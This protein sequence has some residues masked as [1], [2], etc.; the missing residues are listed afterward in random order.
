M[1]LTPAE[2]QAAGLKTGRVQD[3]PMS[4]GLAVN[5]T[6]DAPPESSVSITAPLGGYVQS[7]ELLQGTRV[8]QGQVLAVLRNPEFVTLQKEY[9]ELRSRL[10]FA[11]AEL[12]RQREL[13]EQ[14][15]AP[16]KNYQ[17][18]QAEA[19]ALQV[20]LSAQAAQLRIAGLTVGGAIVPTAALRAP[21]SGFVRAVNVTVGQSVTATE[22][23]FEIVDP[24]HLHV[25][26]VVFEKDVARVQ[27]GQLIRFTLASDSVSTPRERTARVYLVG[28]AIREDRTVLVHGHL[29][30][31][32]DPALLPGL[33]VRATIETGRSN[34]TTLPDGALVR[35]VGQ[36]YAFAVEA[37]GRYRMVPVTPGRS[38]DGYTEVQLPAGVPVSTTFVTDGA[39]SLLGKLKNAEEEE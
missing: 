19:E 25:E 38:E 9:L 2:Q 17:R 4:S 3:R 31:E 13:Y 8:R 6:L 36:Y 5:G 23:L 14:E 27:K 7:T 33:Y 21:R 37:P 24:E 35:F 16:L 30:Q 32:N 22:P 26:L 11:K 28:K 39:Y 18:A 12:A 29:D 20:Q 15:V 10:K 1:T 34:A